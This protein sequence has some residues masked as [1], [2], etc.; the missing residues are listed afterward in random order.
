MTY[1]IIHI[2]QYGCQ[3]FSKDL[4][5]AAPCSKAVL[6]IIKNCQIY[7]RQNANFP[8]YLKK[9]SFVKLGYPGGRSFRDFIS[10]IPAWPHTSKTY[11]TFF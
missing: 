3:K 11:K 9:Q 6:I 2:C 7:K 8:L 5:N 10:T 4:D 1:D